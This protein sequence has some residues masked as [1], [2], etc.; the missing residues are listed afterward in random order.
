ME[1]KKKLEIMEGMLYLAG[2][3]GIDAKIVATVLEVSITKAT[4]LL[5]TLVSQYKKQERQ[6]L[7]LVNLGG[8]YKLTTNP[9][10]FTYF[11]KMVSQSSASLSNA[12]LETLAII[13]YNQPVTR[14]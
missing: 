8:R 6:G 12:A 3:E 5:E 9:N 2:D 7:L 1:D 4:S 14:Q 11:Q 13:A 10:Y